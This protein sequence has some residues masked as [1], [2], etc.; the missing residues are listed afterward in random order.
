VKRWA[1]PCSATSWRSSAIASSADRAASAAAPRLVLWPKRIVYLV[2]ALVLIW[3]GRLLGLPRLYALALPLSLILVETA[4][5][6]I[7]AR[8][9][10]SFEQE[11]ARVAHDLGP[12]AALQLI[13]NEHLLAFVTP[14]YRQAKLAN[15]YRQL[16]QH[17]RAA[18]A[19]RLALEGERRA[20]AAYPLALGLADSLYELGE[21]GEAE[22][23]YR[24]ALSEEHAPPRA[25][26]HLS[27]LIRRR[28]G[29]LEE[30]EA[31]LRRS[32]EQAPELHARCELVTV[33]AQRDKVDEAEWHLQL[34]Q[35]S[36]ALD[37]ELQQ[38]LAEARKAVEEARA[39]PSSEPEPAPRRE[40]AAAT[41]SPASAPPDK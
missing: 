25:C 19:F 22:R 9:R 1:S 6:W 28:G 36:T 39:R 8:R 11:L 20:P 13:D 24:A 7:A 4:L 12:Q 34:C 15:A 2:L 5:Q 16:G 40:R 33:L 27:R 3:C 10:P 38:L 30:A 23:A 21:E 26:L 37:E 29:D 18:E 31:Y 35:E 32:V 17:R 41:S 14:A